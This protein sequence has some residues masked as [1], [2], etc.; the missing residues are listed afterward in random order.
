MN[1][2]GQQ[3]R[4][5]NFAIKDGLPSLA[6][7]DILQDEIGYLWL[8]SNK[9][10]VRFDGNE[11]KGYTTQSSATINTLFFKDNLLYIGS[12]RGLCVKRNNE[13]TCFGNQN[14][15]KIVAIKDAIIL[16][17]TQ[18]IFEL[19]EDDLAPLKINSSLDFSMIH[20]LIVVKESI[21][22][23]SNNGLWK[24]NSLKK[25]SHHKKIM[26]GTIT[27]L[28]VQNNKIIATTSNNGMKII[29]NDRI[30]STI[31]TAKSSQNSTRIDTEIWLSTL[32][33]GIEI[34]NA[35]KLFSTKNKQVQHLRN[36]QYSNCFQRQS[37]P[38]LG[39][40]FQ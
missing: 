5:E 37:K 15:L 11:F 36:K 34:Y 17:T 22:V 18:G 13:I 39:W 6:I 14:I 20:D 19:R 2:S 4:L 16:G 9:G 3:N 23:A 25:G 33:N 38:Y 26:E 35:H 10:L 8:A 1:L 30:S 40:N 29:E 24:L 28:L 31:Y 7:N 21:Y 32:D 27:S 12:K